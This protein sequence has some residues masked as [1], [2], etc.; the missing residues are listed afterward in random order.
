MRKIILVTGGCGYIGS[1]T[2]LS[3][4]ESGANLVVIDNLSNSSS[5]SISRIRKICNKEVKL[6][7]G[8]ICDPL[9]LNDIFLNYN[10]DSVIHFAGLKSV[11]ES[12]R[13]PLKYYENNVLGSL[14]LVNAMD[15]S[16]VRKLVFSSSATVYG[17]PTCVPIDE[18]SSVGSIENPY[19]R[20]KFITEQ[21]LNDLSLSD[22]RW[23]IAVLRYFNPVGAHDSGLLGEDPNG[24]PN[25][26]VP[27][28]SLVA[29]GELEELSVFGDDYPT[30]DGTGVRDYI[31]VM[32]L[33]EGHLKALSFINNNHGIHTWNLG[34]GIGYSVLQI[35]DAFEKASKKNIPYKITS[36]RKGDISEC[37]SDA[38]KAARDL[39]WRASRNLEDMMRDTWRWQSNNPKGYRA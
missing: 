36:R 17:K 38:S 32:D 21:M 20:S 28:M 27:Y 33:A 26:L 30:I 18:N 7:I 1:H 19:G 29:T 37:W 34:T 6:I 2:V 31:H 35:I 24:I 11:G 4:L 14:N 39:N 16:G 13:K 15:R 25:N 3:L 8:D 23:S 12:S 10:I 5:E 9:F 22:P